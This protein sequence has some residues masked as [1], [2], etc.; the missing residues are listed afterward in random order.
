MGFQYLCTSPKSQRMKTNHYLLTILAAGL[1]ISCGRGDNNS[2]RTTTHNVFVTNPVTTGT[3]TRRTYAAVVE[4][5][6]TISAGFKTAGQ[7]ERILLKEGD[8]VHRGQLMALLDTVDYALGVSQLREQVARQADEYAR[9]S[10]LHATGN[11]SENEFLHATSSLRQMRLQLELNENKLKYCRLNAPCDGVITK[12]NFENSEMVDAG[13]PVFEIMDI[14]MLEVIVDLPV[15]E[16]QRRDRF[17]SFTALLP[18][19]ARVPLNMLSLT[20]RAD[21][22]QLYKLKLAMPQ[23]AGQAITPGMNVNVAI[24]LTGDDTQTVTI[25][26][27][28]L[29]DNAAGAQSV[30]VLSPADSTIHAVPVTTRGVVNTDGTINVIE[31]LDEND[32]IVRAGV[33]SLT[34]GEKVKVIEPASSTNVGSVL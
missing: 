10:Q 6:R 30:W 15:N 1:L 25:P 28:A 34:E 13:T 8:R 4:E 33:N 7:I 19:G 29:F 3:G 9:K 17:E 16:F 14:S 12:V 27:R 2:N 22:N 5:A 31:G 11:L 18:G 26:A 21:N 20:P 24:A 23:S 32:I